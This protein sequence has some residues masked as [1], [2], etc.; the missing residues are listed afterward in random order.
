MLRRIEQ[1]STRITT[2]PSHTQPI[3]FDYL[4]DSTSS[5]LIKTG[6]NQTLGCSQE[7]DEPKFQVFEVQVQVAAFS[8]QTHSQSS[9]QKAPADPGDL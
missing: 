8:S 5:R 3:P 4:S 2:D 6:H 1:K 7:T 9:T